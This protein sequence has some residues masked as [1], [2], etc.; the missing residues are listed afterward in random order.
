MHLA[1]KTWHMVGVLLMII[2]H[3][4]V[5]KEVAIAL[6]LGA[7]VIFVIP[8]IVRQYIPRLNTF[9]VGLFKTV[10][11][12][13]EVQRLSGNS[14]LILGVLATILVFPPMVVGL[15]LLFLAF[16]DPIA[17]CVGILYGKNKLIGSKSVQGF[18]A[19]W[20]VCGSLTF[21]FLYS[22]QLL[23]PQVFLVSFLG[24]M[25]GALSELVPIGK[26]DD[27]FTLPLLSASGLFLL[28]KFF[29]VQF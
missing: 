6:L 9:F 8:D 2:I 10:I 17:S 20:V 1:R 5:T 28:L 11:R 29:G 21:W 18:M 25:I 27:N 12:E 19:A 13:S 4:R 22:H 7:V 23:I 24:G 16:A 26:F 15:S 14:Y 3:Q